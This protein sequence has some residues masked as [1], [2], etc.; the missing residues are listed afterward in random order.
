M[1]DTQDECQEELEALLDSLIL[2][3]FEIKKWTEYHVNLCRPSDGKK[4]KI[5]FQKS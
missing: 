5:R 1:D 2:E 4:V 3:G